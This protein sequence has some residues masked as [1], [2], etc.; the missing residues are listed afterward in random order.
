MSDQPEITQEAA[1][2][3]LAAVRAFVAWLDAEDS[4]PN[5]GTQSRDTH[6]EGERI[7]REWY[8]RNLRLCDEAQRLGH[9][10]IAAAEGRADG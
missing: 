4:M 6:P 7:W 3:M 10:A 8:D 1:R 2:Q 5:Y 9:A